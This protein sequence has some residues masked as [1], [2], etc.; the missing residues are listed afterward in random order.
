M[1]R[2]AFLKR[3][4]QVKAKTARLNLVSPRWLILWL[5][6]VALF[7]YVWQINSLAT[8]GYQVR[9]LEKE[10]ADLKNTNKQLENQSAN[11]RSLDGLKKKL[12]QLSLVPVANVQYLSPP[13]S[14]VAQK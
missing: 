7:A 2:F 3:K 6:I 14:I 4:M 9:E 5:L 11:L 1:T 13:S 10:V 12:D 8:Y